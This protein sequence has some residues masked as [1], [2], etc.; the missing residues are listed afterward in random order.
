MKIFF[1]ITVKHF[2]NKCNKNIYETKA[3]MAFKYLYQKITVLGRTLIF[4]CAVTFICVN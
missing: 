4:C 3:L 1:Y 2:I